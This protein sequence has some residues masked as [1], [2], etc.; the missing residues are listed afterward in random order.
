MYGFNPSVFLVFDFKWY[1]WLY[2]IFGGITVQL[3]RAKS[4]CCWS[5]GTSVNS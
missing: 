3:L 4:S 5:S 1:L 2:Q